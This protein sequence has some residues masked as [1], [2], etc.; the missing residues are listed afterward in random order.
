VIVITVRDLS[1]DYI[2]KY[3]YSRSIYKINC[4]FMKAAEDAKE[5]DCQLA[6]EE[7][8]RSSELLL[9]LLSILIIQC[10]DCETTVFLNF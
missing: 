3:N 9:R 10:A 7:S 4:G 2:D 1:K 5:K 8:Q 6:S